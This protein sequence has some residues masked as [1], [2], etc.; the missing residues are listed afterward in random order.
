MQEY[1]V[2]FTSFAC[3]RRP[4]YLLSEGDHAIIGPSA[5]MISRG[6][7]QVEFS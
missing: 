2:L 5:A 4:I 3:S 6:G 1:E 7:V